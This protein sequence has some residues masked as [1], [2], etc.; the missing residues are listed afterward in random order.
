MFISALFDSGCDSSEFQCSNGECKPA[1][2]ECDG[3][4][5]CGDYSDEQNCGGMYI[6]IILKTKVLFY[7]MSK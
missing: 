4:N 6:L 5:D 7:D 1:S 2:Y 3:D